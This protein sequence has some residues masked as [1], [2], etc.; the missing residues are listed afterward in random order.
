MIRKLRI[1]TKISLGFMI[2]I[3]LIAVLGI[4]AVISLNSFAT[5]LDT[6]DQATQR[7]TLATQIEDNFNIGVGAARGYIA[8]GDEKFAKQMETTISNTIVMEYQLTEMV[9]E[10]ERPEMQ[11][12]TQVTM[13]YGDGVIN[14]LS[15]VV[16]AYH[17]ELAAGNAERAQELKNE[18]YAVNRKITPYSDQIAEILQT[19]MTTNKAI[20]EGNVNSAKAAMLQQMIFTGV[21]GGIAVIIG[22]GF[23]IILTRMVCRPLVRMLSAANAYAD[24]DLSVPVDFESADELGELAVALNKM[25]DSFKNIISNILQSSR[26]VAAASDTMSASVE[27]SAQAAEQVDMSTNQVAEDAEKQLDGVN[28]TSAVAEQMVAN[29]EQ[30]AANITTVVDASKGTGTAAHAGLKTVDVAVRQMQS[31]EQAVVGSAQ[32]VAQLGEYSQAIGQIVNTISGIASQT[33]LLALNAAIEAARAGEQGRGFAVVADEVRKLAEQSGQSA[34]QIAS[35]I[36]AIQGATNQAIAA[37]ESGTREVKT[38]TEVVTTAGKAFSEIAEHIDQVAAQVQEISYAITE[39]AGGSEQ[40]VTTIQDFAVIS[41]HIVSQ[42]QTVSAATQ[43][44][45]SSM[46]AITASGQSLSQMALDLHDA[47]NRFK[48]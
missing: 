45:S 19:M 35:L 7:L 21:V 26:Q 38:G 44:Q 41:K 10:L 47:V 39:M 36:H 16:R 11:K 13:K 34:K 48:I 6:I 22:I 43:Q 29:V 20:V 3:I 33:N 40:I 9:D 2:M 42:T 23:S 8:Y 12:L 28:A 5:N 31:I 14:D 25:Q 4:V 30:I 46:Q 27:Q 32:I 1:G 15:P 24:G 37:M 18:A 17:K